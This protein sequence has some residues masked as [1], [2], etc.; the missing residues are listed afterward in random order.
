ME[1]ITADAIFFADGMFRESLI[2]TR[3]TQSVE[4]WEWAS[5][6]LLGRPEI[7]QKMLDLEGHWSDQLVFLRISYRFNF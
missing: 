4:R 3:D 5:R 2:V 6:M 7:S 1:T